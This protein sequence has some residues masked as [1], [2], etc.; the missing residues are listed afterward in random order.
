M[1][2]LERDLAALGRN[3]APRTLLPAVM[4]GAGLADGYAELETPIGVFFVAWNGSG[5]S[6]V[7]RALSPEDFEDWFRHRVGRRAV[8][9]DGMPERLRGQLADA[10]FGRRHSRL[11]FDLRE[12][13]PFE[14]DVLTK[15][16]EIPRGEVRTYAWVAREIGRPAAVRA[17]GTALAH[18]PIPIL[19]PCH[20]V[21]RSDGMIGQ[22]GGGGP[23]AKR[24]ILA[25]EGVSADEL[26]ALARERTRFIGSR[27]TGVFCVPTC[28]DAQRVAPE[29]RL[30]FQDE[31]SA[32]AAGFR[33]CGHCR[34]ARAS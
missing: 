23:S 26:E 3:R 21:V 5:V 22:Y 11:R 24:A 4:A 16:L 17:V 19:I 34:P 6:A 13:R 9:A 12:L 33:P 30:K 18:N 1:E 28:R 2:T 10:V 27:T 8:R 20:R 14:R 25:H 15:T 29:N 7:M 31:G 32:L